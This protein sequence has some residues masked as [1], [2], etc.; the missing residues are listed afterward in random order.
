MKTSK[1]TPAITIG[2]IHTVLVCIPASKSAVDSIEMIVPPTAGCSVNSH[3]RLGFNVVPDGQVEGAS[4]ISKSRFVSGGHEGEISPGWHKEPSKEV[5][6]GQPSTAHRGT[7]SM[8]APSMRVVPRGHDGCWVPPL[9][10]WALP[11]VE[12]VVSV[13]INNNTIEPTLIFNYPNS[14]ILIK[15]VMNLV[16]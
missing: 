16:V 11:T 15:S 3:K 8:V 4:Q 7:P 12:T 6:T 10:A 13:K 2:I 9:P 1:P 5:P 14:I